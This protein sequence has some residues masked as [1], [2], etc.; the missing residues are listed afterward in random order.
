MRRLLALCGAIA[1]AA[2]NQVDAPDVN[3]TLPTTDLNVA[4]TFVL[5]SANG[6]APPYVVASN[7]VTTQTLLDD[8]IVIHDDLTWA[9]TTNYGTERLSDGQTTVTF[10]SS[11]GTYAIADGHINFTMVQGGSSTFKGA[12]VG[13]DL[14]VDFQG[15]LFRYAR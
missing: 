14:S 6:I 12:V 3:F 2:C 15:R 9:D 11:S 7:G 4:G 8:R 10:T 5:T 13:N 1:L